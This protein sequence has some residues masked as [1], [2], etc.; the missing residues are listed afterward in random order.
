[1]SSSELFPEDLVSIRAGMESS[2]GHAIHPTANMNS[3]KRRTAVRIGSMLSTFS[4]IPLLLLGS[5][6]SAVAEGNQ[7]RKEA[8]PLRL[9]DPKTVYY[10]SKSGKTFRVRY[11]SLSDGSLDFVKL[12]MPDNTVYTLPRT[13]SASGAKYTDGRQLVWW[14]KGKAA[15]VY[16]IG[17][18]G[19]HETVYSD[20][21]EVHHQI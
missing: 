11:Y 4:V 14:T 8:E 15:W 21:K 16:E 5:P 10:Q 18:D 13:V 19:E 12:T 1:M 17:E 3:S 20:L 9:G 2:K 7:P 6:C